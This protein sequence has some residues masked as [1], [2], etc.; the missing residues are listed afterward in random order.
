M[1]VFIIVLLFFDRVRFNKSKKYFYMLCAVE[2]FQY[3]FV[4]Y[5]LATRLMVMVIG[6]LTTRLLVEIALVLSVGC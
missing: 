1:G 2:C 3:L 5:S 4:Y 6:S